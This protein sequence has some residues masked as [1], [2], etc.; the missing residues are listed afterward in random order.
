MVRVFDGADGVS[1]FLQFGYQLFDQGGFAGLRA[2]DNRYNRWHK[3]NLL[4]SNFTAIIYHKDHEVTQRLEENLIISPFVPLVNFVVNIKI[5][6]NLK[7][8]P[9]QT[10]MAVCHKAEPASQGETK[11][12]KKE[13]QAICALA[14][15]EFCSAN[16]QRI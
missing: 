1:A 6:I 12:R 9:S 4:Y 2:S 7:Y 8:L 14:V 15:L 10:M 13:C 16:L 11:V 3:F 5:S